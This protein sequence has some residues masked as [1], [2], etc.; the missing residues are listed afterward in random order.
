[1]VYTVAIIFL[2]FALSWWRPEVGLA[3]SVQSYLIRS[4]VN[5]P[6]YADQTNITNDDPFLS[7][8]VPAIIFGVILIKMF[9]RENQRFRFNI[10]LLDSLFYLLG[11][12][13]LF[14]SIY[15]PLKN[16][17]VLVSL[18][19]FI[20]GISYYYFARLYFSKHVDVTKAAI[21]FM[22]ATW[23][24]A[25]TLG[26]YAYIKSFG[27]DYFRLTIGN[28]HPIPFS[29][30]IASGILINIYWLFKPG[31]KSIQKIMLLIP[32]FLLLV[33]FIS[34]N[35]RGTIVSLAVSLVFIL[36]AALF[37]GK[38]RLRQFLIGI[39]GLFGAFYLILNILPDTI[40]T[41]KNNL[42]LI[43]SSE[44]GV[45]IDERSMAH[46]DA[47]RLFN[48]HIMFGV[49]TAGFKNYS[50]IV[51]AHNAFLE[52]LSEN[53][54]IGG[55]ALGLIFLVISAMLLKIIFK[56]TGVTLLIASLVVLNMVEMQFSFTLWMHKWFFL[57]CGLLVS[58]MVTEKNVDNLRVEGEPTTKKL[59]LKKPLINAGSPLINKYK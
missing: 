42:E 5:P 29:L 18:K 45:S 49:G 38:V 54:L 50:E 6:A 53:G 17:A 23:V 11:A 47:L 16:D 57:F 59:T 26:S 30:L 25:I 14:G 56:H 19:F 44:H 43:V 51:Y 31:T 24:L 8:A 32:L 40:E 3:V 12:I 52:V 58:I 34:A 21:N 7:A 41:V 15:S 1:M 13:L 10:R 27:L 4:A 2:V 39:L 36:L 20:L 9:R 28:A 37:Q 33:I 46:R 48:D 35:T 55:I 22:N